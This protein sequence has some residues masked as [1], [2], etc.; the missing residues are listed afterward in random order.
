MTSGFRSVDRKEQKNSLMLLPV[1]GSAGGKRK[2][3][4]VRAM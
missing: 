4:V 1:A 3:I 2:R